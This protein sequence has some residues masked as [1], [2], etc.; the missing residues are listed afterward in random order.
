MKIQFFEN[1]RGLDSRAIDGGIYLIELLQ[2]CM[3]A[4]DNAISSMYIDKGDLKEAEAWLHGDRWD[5][6]VEKSAR[7]KE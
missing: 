4:I 7:C 5:F 3:Q 6:E 1:I 2:L